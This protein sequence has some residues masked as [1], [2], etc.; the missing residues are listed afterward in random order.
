MLLVLLPVALVP[1]ALDIRINA[2]AIGLII[3]PTALIDISISME[4]FALA[5]RLVVLPIALILGRVGPEHIA[6][7]VSQS[8]LPLACIHSTSHVSVHSVLQFGVILV[9]STQSFF[10]LVALKVLALHLTSE[11]HDAILASLEES[12]D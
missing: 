1:G 6:S 3:H 8:T 4:E 7:A 5:A 11:F 2:E 9:S 10:G 12:T